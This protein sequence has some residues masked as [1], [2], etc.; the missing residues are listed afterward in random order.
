MQD[1]T[2]TLI[3][4]NLFWEDPGKNIEH[5]TGLLDRIT[6]PAD[7]ILLPEMFN[8]GFTINTASC[9][10]SMEGPSILFLKE[11]SREK[12][13]PIM[14]TLIV[15]EENKFFNRMV[16]AFPDGHL[17]TYDKRHL[18]RLVEEYKILKGGN[19]RTVISIK[20]WNIM[21][22][23]CY[24]LR[25]PVW[26]KNTY[27]DGK[28][29]YDLLVCLANWPNVRAHAWKTLLVGRAIDNQS[30]TIG[31]NRVGDDGNGIYHSGDSMV[32][33]AKG[34]IV[35]AAEAGKEEIITVTL[36][37]QELRQYRDSFT[38]GLDWDTFIINN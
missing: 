35:V 24:D 28:Y 20:G 25:F 21:P 3:Q 29:E 6:E 14:A 16:C 15:K 9:G 5:F 38:V 23:I 10:E 32:T 34:Q 13:T 33:D 22:I 26:S 1:L 27:K 4:T 7:L 17:E 30:Y 31:L 12:N 11:K 18:F 19:K 8:T 37:A 2:V 36:S